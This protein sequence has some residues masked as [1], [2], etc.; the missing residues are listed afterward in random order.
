MYIVRFMEK[1]PDMFLA[2]SELKQKH[3]NVK[4]NYDNLYII[5]WVKCSVFIGTVDV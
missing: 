1:N 4:Y 5:K 3:G 2:H